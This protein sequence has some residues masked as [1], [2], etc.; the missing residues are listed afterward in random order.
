MKIYYTR[1]TMGCI[2][3]NSGWQNLIMDT[4]RV[5]CLP[6]A[7]ILFCYNRLCT[8][9][10]N[11]YMENKM[12]NTDFYFL[13]LFSVLLLLQAYFIYKIRVGQNILLLWTVL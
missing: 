3:H 10:L 5:M 13:P 9:W 1:Q 7:Y 4:K 8:G 2:Y 12:G 11:Y 6:T